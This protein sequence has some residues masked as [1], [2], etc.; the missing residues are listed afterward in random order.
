MAAAQIKIDTS[1]WR[2]RCSSEKHRIDPGWT[3]GR[4]GHFFLDRCKVDTPWELSMGVVEEGCLAPGRH[5]VNVSEGAL[6]VL[7]D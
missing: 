6:D 7:G 1:I 3:L 4:L 5:N 2:Y